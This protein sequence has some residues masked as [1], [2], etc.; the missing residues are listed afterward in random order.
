MVGGVLAFYDLR[1][2]V[3]LLL[4]C[5]VGFVRGY[6]GEAGGMGGEA[7]LGF[8]GCL[9]D[10]AFNYVLSDRAERFGDFDEGGRRRSQRLSARQ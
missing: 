10:F 7:R 5:D 9:Q 6:G 1:I 3:E 8:A 4:C 2:V